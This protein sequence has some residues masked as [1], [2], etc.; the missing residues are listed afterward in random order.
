MAKP[1]LIIVEGAIGSGKS[2]LS[3]SLRENIP[4]STL[5]DLGSI[6]NDSQAHSFI[7]HSNILSMLFDVKLVQSNFILSRSFISNEVY[8]RLGKKD[9]DNSDNFK[10]HVNRLNM[11]KMIYDIK[12]IILASNPDEFERRLS[13]REKF[14]YVKHSVEESIKQQREYLC[15]ADE[16]RESDLEVRVVNNGGLSQEDLYKLIVTELNLNG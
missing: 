1:K 10:Y 8:S 7:Y 6:G 4:N 9:Y 5:L 13:V 12:I 11:L 14:Q 3:R 2:T 16:L 15:I